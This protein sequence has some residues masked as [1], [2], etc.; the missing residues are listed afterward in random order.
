MGRYAT[1]VLL[2]E[3]SGGLHLSDGEYDVGDHIE[4]DGWVQTHANIVH[5]INRSAER[6]NE[7]RI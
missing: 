2:Q 6:L 4:G 5:E 7:R 3:P 1:K